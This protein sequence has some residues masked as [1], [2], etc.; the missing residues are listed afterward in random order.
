MV[1]FISVCILPR[2]GDAGSGAAGTN[3]AVSNVSNAPIGSALDVWHYTVEGP[4]ALPIAEAAHAPLGA[5]LVVV[6]HAVLVA[7]PT[8][9]A[10][11]GYMDLFLPFL[12]NPSLLHTGSCRKTAA[13]TPP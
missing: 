12:G 1:S 9:E 7:L 5:V 2:S 10:R 8:I 4:V 6:V 13:T 3:V 11:Q